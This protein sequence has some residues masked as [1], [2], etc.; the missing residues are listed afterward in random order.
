MGTLRYTVY[1]NAP[2]KAATHKIATQREK[3]MNWNLLT[4]EDP[5]V[6]ESS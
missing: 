4:E 3:E 6:V 5:A 1:S 2:K